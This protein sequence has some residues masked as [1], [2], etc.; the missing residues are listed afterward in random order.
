MH[1]L[2]AVFDMRAMVS[3]PSFIPLCFCLL[4]LSACIGGGG[5]SGPA[6]VLDYGLKGG[7]GSAGV[8]TVA[9]TD[10]VWNVSQRYR[11]SMQDVIS[12]NGLRPPY[13]LNVG[14]RLRL[15]PP[16]TYAVRSGDTLYGI[17]RTFGVSQTSLARLN[18]IPSPYVIN[19]GQVLSLPS[20]A[21]RKRVQNV[22]TPGRKADV[23][24]TARVTPSVK[25]KIK[26]S[27]PAPARSGG[28][29][30]WPVNGP[31]ISSYGPKKDGLHNDGINI[32]A[33]RGTSVAA[34]ENGVVVYA[35]NELKGYGNLILVRHADRWMTAYAH[36]DGFDVKKGQEVRRGQVIGK[37]GAS[38][39][40]ST[41]Q[42]HFEIRRGTDA[43]DPQRYLASGS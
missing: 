6:P 25:P 7:A 41:P 35:N 21:A 42:L 20:M 9:A 15:P 40:V 37:V 33:N 32:R 17:S 31:V 26:V 1:R 18:N 43:I 22:P 13:M 3:F 5:S 38:G 36:L 29:F 16:Q 19:R 34:S 4:M 14:Q 12:V 23:V 11:V 10:T 24:Q 28:K 27:K 2:M 8:H 30:A 39:G